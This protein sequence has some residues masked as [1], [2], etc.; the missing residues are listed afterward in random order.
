[1]LAFDRGHFEPKNLPGHQ[2]HYNHKAS[3][4]P[5]EARQNYHAQAAF[6]AFAIL[7]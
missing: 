2:E 4:K 7:K 3:G 6:E 1:M 5:V